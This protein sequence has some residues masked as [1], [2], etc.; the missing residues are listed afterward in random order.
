MIKVHNAMHC[1]SVPS[2][3]YK[4]QVQLADVVDTSGMRK[5]E[6]IDG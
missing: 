5:P 6:D 1:K 3:V 4:F 2:I